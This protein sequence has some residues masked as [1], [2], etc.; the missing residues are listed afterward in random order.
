MTS[1][2]MTKKP[3]WKRPGFRLALVPLTALFLIGLQAAPS[4]ALIFDPA[5]EALAADLGDAGWD[6][7]NVFSIILG[8]IELVMLVT[9][10]GALIAVV[11]RF[12]RGAEAWM[13]WALTMGGSI[14][15]IAFSTFLVGAIYN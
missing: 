7:T 6:E 12:D 5:R 9:P 3:I 14:G 15:V 13:P 11:A 8:I 10:V 1:L 4:H 2:Q